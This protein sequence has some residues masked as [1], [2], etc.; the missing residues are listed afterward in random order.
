MSVN[1]ALVRALQAF[2]GQAS[3]TMLVVAVAFTIGP[4]AA[5][6]ILAAAS[7]PWLFAI[8][9]PLGVAGLR[10]GM[11]PATTR[12]ATLDARTAL[13]NVGAFGLLA[14]RRRRPSG[15][16]PSCSPELA[17]VAVFFVLLL[18]RQAASRRPC[19]PST[20]S[21]GPCSAVVA[22][23]RVHVCRARAGLR[24]AAILF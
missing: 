18:R 19:C 21:A 10:P 15:L 14:V 5:S 7:W 23:G 13:Y 3:A 2:A 4:T 9:V 8:N 11:L 24:L 12:A 6:L 1:T 20:C 22:D 16:I 17:A